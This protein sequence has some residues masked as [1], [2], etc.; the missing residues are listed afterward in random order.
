MASLFNNLRSPREKDHHHHGHYEEKRVLNPVGPLMRSTTSLGR[1][2]S[3]S[4]VAL[5]VGSGGQH[6]HG[7]GHR[8]RHSRKSNDANRRA[9]LHSAIRTQGTESDTIRPSTS[10][11][12]IARLVD[13]GAPIGA[14]GGSGSQTM[15]PPGQHHAPVPLSIPTTGANSSP[16]FTSSP[17][18]QGQQGAQQQ[19]PLQ[20]SG[21]RRHTANSVTLA[22]AAAAAAELTSLRAEKE[23]FLLQLD[24]QRKEKQKVMVSLPPLSK[25][26]GV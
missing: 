21:S 11:Q 17:R 6:G 3:T 23:A 16:L 14:V 15:P 18:Q 1:P 7:H 20:Q 10:V 2:L 13:F 24:K 5:T 9:S 8:H 19:P 4:S 12:D 22:A 25:S 26:H